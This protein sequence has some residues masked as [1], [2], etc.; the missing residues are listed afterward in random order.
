MTD[1]GQGTARKQPTFR[2]Q[3]LS[4]RGIA[5]VPHP[6]WLSSDG[7]PRA[8]PNVSPLRN[9]GF[10][11]AALVRENQWVFISP[12]HKALYFFGGPIKSMGCTVY[13][14]TF[15]IIYHE[16]QPFM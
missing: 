11:K 4:E 3:L 1:R 15:T 14:P 2:M 12:A 7:Y 5:K 13:L 6:H 8:A 10:N 9:I 16:N